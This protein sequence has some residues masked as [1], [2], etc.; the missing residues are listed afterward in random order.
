[1]TT[2][3]V[4]R[5]GLRLAVDGAALAFY[6]QDE[7]K[8]TIPLKSLER[9]C[10]R[11][12]LE[13][14]ASVLGKMGEEGVGVIILSGRKKEPVLFMPSLRVD[15]QRRLAQYEASKQEEFCLQQSKKWVTQKLTEQ[16]TVLT[17]LEENYPEHRLS[18][19]HGVESL[20]LAIENTQKVI[21]KMSLRGIEGASAARYFGTWSKVLPPYWQFNGRTKRPPLDPL[22]ATMS[23]CY[24]LLHFEL[25]REIHL[26]GLDPFIGVYHEAEYSRES[27]ACDLV[28]PLRPL[29]DA[30]IIELFQRKELRVDY[31]TMFSDACMMGKAGR[32]LFYQ[33][34]DDQAKQW[35]PKMRQLCR[36][37]LQSLRQFSTEKNAF[38]YV[39][40]MILE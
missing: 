37:F 18:I 31:F 19:K 6:D 25:V 14:N 38:D 4:D 34:Y 15:A 3:F 8:G 12:D 26:I 11:G 29:C 20:Q 13:M 16:L 22:N 7:R 10:I 24:T 36:D 5:K 39:E 17:N 30:W 33:L 27:L 2:L 1:M 21:D 28:E 23:L 35:R 40:Q 32:A 9:V